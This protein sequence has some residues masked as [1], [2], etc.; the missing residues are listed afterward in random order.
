MLDYSIKATIIGTAFAAWFAHGWYLNQQLQSVHKKLDN[1]LD[2]FD[3]LRRYLYEI[4]PQFDE[5][6]DLMAG[7]LHNKGGA[8][9]GY[10]ANEFEKI[11]KSQGKR[12][13]NTSFFE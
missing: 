6:R 13:M 1:V 2:A 11:K 4:D 5:E 3:G 8:L 10:E 9:A 12:T 7:F